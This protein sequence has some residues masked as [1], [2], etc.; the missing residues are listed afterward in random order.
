MAKTGLPVKVTAIEALAGPAAVCDLLAVSRGL[1]RLDARRVTRSRIMVT[2]AA[3]WGSGDGVPGGNG[4]RGN[5]TVRRMFPQERPRSGGPEQSNVGL[6]FRRMCRD[7][8]VVGGQP[9]PG[10]DLAPCP[11]SWV[12]P[13]GQ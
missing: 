11:V 9:L 2:G 6:I 12:S 8:G 1:G 13:A 10:V 4:V 7:L 5:R 3:G